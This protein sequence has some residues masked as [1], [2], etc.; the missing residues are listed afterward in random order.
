MTDASIFAKPAH[1]AR[2]KTNTNIQLFK[3]FVLA[4]TV[5]HFTLSKNANTQ[6]I[7]CSS[8]LFVCLFSA[9]S[10]VPAP[11]VSAAALGCVPPPFRKKVDLR[12]LQV[13][14]QPEVDTL[15]MTVC[16]TAQANDVTFV[17][18]TLHR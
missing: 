15:T 2:G 6:S 18:N 14:Q 13:L 3:Y 12:H 17:R 9:P 16:T 5:I 1:A 7:H 10:A 11:A 8:D 4:L